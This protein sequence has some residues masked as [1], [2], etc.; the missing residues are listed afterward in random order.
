VP[1]GR[2]RL[3]H[4]TRPFHRHL[5]DQLA[6]QTP[7][8][9]SCGCGCACHDVSGHWHRAR[10]R[11]SNG[12]LRNNQVG[13]VRLLVC[14]DAAAKGRRAESSV[15]VASRF[16]APG[17]HVRGVA[18]LH[19]ALDLVGEPCESPIEN[20][21]PSIRRRTRRLCFARWPYPA[22]PFVYCDPPKFHRCTADL[23]KAGRTNPRRSGSPA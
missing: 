2:V 21:E 6:D 10:R 16:G 1:C 14:T 18:E 8:A 22:A 3:S 4:R 15:C 23:E 20:D 17:G 19:A 7:V 5:R 12:G 13:R 9:S 11:G